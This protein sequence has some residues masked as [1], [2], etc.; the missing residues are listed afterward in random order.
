MNNRWSS[1]P[2]RRYSPSWLHLL[3][4]KR[5]ELR[6][7]TI[8]YWH[9]LGDRT[10][11][12]WDPIFRPM[13]WNC[14]VP[15][16]KSVSEELIRPGGNG[17]QNSKGNRDVRLAFRDCPWISLSTRASGSIVTW[18]TTCKASTLGLRR[19]VLARLD[20][21]AQL[22][23]P[24]KFKI[25]GHQPYN[26]VLRFQYSHLMRILWGYRKL[27]LINKIFIMTLPRFPIL[28]L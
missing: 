23:H 10:T 2:E 6:E 19:K 8:M 9:T 1:L 5:T 24:H 22:C 28:L 26:F 16:L 13:F 3:V 14:T 7:Y 12:V 4:N 27:H 25:L 17:I 20:C 11:H 18:W 21:T 15:F